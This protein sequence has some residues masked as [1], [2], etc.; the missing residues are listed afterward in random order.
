MKYFYH[1]FMLVLMVCVHLRGQDDASSIDFRY[2]P[3]TNVG[4]GYGYEFVHGDI[5]DRFGNNFDL[6]SSVERI[7][8][9][10]FL[11]GIEGSFKFGSDV[12]EDVLN[13]LRIHKDNILGADNG[14]SEVYFREQG[15]YLGATLGKIITFNESSRS[16]LRISLGAGMLAHKIRLIDENYSLPQIENDYGKGYD[17]LTRG[18]AIKEFIGW[19]HISDDRRI[20]FRIGIEFTQG[21]TKEIRAVNF[22]TGEKPSGNRFDGFIGIKGMWNL[23]FYSENVE[24]PEIFY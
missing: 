22:D 6:S 23:P 18:W 17:R 4:I 7:T 8:S 10:N 15:L 13:Y 9:K 21:F 3:I 12:K 11:F 20:N 5:S 14:L 2:A 16:G 24:A 19:Q 1:T